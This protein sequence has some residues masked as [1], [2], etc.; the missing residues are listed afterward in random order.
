MEVGVGDRYLKLVQEGALLKVYFGGGSS[1]FFKA[2]V[3][4][5]CLCG[6]MHG[7]NVCREQRTILGNWFSPSMCGSGDQYEVEVTRQNNS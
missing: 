4:C 2:F 1:I 7:I 5:V 6:C 3:L